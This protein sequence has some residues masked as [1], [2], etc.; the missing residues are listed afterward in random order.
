MYQEILENVTSLLQS[1]R[2]HREPRRN[3]Y[4]MYCKK[5]S[6]R[7][8]CVPCGSEVDFNYAALNYHKLF[9]ELRG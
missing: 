3:F 5:K 1:Y 8:L 9:K 6:L 2:E 4:A 7:F